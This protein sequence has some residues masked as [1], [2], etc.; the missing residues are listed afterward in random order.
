MYRPYR[1]IPHAEKRRLQMGLGT[2]EIK[3]ALNH[4]EIIRPNHEDRT[5]YVAGR[6]A[7]VVR[8]SDGAT[9]TI[10]WRTVDDNYTRPVN[11]AAS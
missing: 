9:M 5:I 8:D 7:V 1:P 2:K 11:L 3:R 6:I 4:P 10:L